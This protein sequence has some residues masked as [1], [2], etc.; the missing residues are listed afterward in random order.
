MGAQTR[1]PRPRPRSV[2]GCALVGPYRSFGPKGTYNVG[3]PERLD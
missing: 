1:P 2:V 3:L